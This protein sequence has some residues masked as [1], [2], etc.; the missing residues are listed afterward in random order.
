MRVDTDS[1]PLLWEEWV[2]VYR[3]KRI[4]EKTGVCVDV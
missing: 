1:Q 4:Q 3:G 2:Q